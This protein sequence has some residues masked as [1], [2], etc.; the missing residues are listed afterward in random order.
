LKFDLA[1]LGR[2]LA[3]SLAPTGGEALLNKVQAMSGSVDALFQSVHA[4]AAA[5][6]PA[7]LDD[8]GLVPALKCLVTTLQSRTG[9]RCAIDVAPGLA[10]L[11]SNCAGIA[12]ECDAS[13]RRLS[14]SSAAVPGWR[15]GDVRSD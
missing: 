9:A 13:C 12:D 5:L 7:M 2:R 1:W 8:L 3:Q 14:G 11:V 10:S 6:R 4:T 15:Q